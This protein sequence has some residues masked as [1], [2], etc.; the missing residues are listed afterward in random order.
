MTTI[1]F[2]GEIPIL[3]LLGIINRIFNLEKKQ[4]IAS[5]YYS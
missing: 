1:V 2:I 5:N 3:I 4:N